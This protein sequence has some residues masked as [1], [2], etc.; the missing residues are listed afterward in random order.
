MKIVYSGL[1][2]S[3][4]SLYLAMR[5]HE[6]LERNYKWKLKSGIV[7]GIASNLIFS[8]G[9]EEKAKKYGIPIFY[10]VNL[11]DLIKFEN[12]DVIIDELATYFDAR[13]W[14]SL[15][16][17]VR[18]WLTQAAKT[19]IEI[20]GTAQDFAQ[21]D[22]SFRR[23]VNELH[24][25]RKLFGSPRPSPTRPPVRFIWGFCYMR[26]LDPNGYDEDEF[27]SISVI[28][29]GFL[30]RRKWCEI[31]DTN[32]KIM[33]SRPAPYKHYFRKCEESE[34]TFCKVEHR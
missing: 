25:I 29:W 18:R 5:T 22:K 6:I 26:Q 7:R 17:D 2:S 24:H 1:E 12:V 15:S 21:V 33:L 8:K 28:P 19:G 14:E 10:W 23:L 32:A 20:Y 13:G 34:C 11:Y 9:F 30:I 16:L 27:K 31:F 3:G 4:K